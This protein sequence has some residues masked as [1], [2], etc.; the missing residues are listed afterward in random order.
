MSLQ[1]IYLV[2]YTEKQATTII[3]TNKIQ[4]FIRKTVMSTNDKT[5]IKPNGIKNYKTFKQ[6][7]RKA[8][9]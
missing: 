4:D 1:G 7:K 9:S 2:L 6:I 5:W 3:N 8:K